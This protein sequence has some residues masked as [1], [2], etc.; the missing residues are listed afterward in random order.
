MFIGAGMILQLSH[1][2]GVLSTLSSRGHPEMERDST[3]MGSISWV[4]LQKFL[5]PWPAGQGPG[6]GQELSALP[7]PHFFQETGNTF[8]FPIFFFPNQIL[9]EKIL[10]FTGGE[11]LILQQMALLPRR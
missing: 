5:L 1:T 11:E 2:C 8:S 7:R 3:A 6:L 10:E 4:I 9:F